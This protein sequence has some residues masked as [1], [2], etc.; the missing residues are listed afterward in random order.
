MLLPCNGKIKF[1]HIQRTVAQLVMCLAADM[2]LTADR[3]VARS[4]SFVEIDHEIISTV[5]VLPFA[6]S[7]MFDRKRT[8]FWGLYTIMSTSLSFELLIIQ[9]KTS[10]PKDFQFTR[11]NVFSKQASNESL[12]IFA[13]VHYSLNNRNIRNNK[14]LRL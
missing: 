4:H 12:K 10:S 11:L 6:D 2:C 1:S 7:L 13:T 3:G 8:S 14:A 5:I 9:N